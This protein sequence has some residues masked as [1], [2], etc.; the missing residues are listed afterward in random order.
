MSQITVRLS[1]RELQALIN[2]A[3]SERRHPREQ[4]ACIIH[5]MFVQH[6]LLNDE[7]ASRGHETLL[8]RQPCAVN[9]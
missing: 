4:A 8:L 3:E 2:L 6:G 1:D 9:G 7:N 5:T